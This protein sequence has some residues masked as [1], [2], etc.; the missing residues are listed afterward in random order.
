ML[1]VSVIVLA[2]G[3]AATTTAFSK[4]NLDVQTKMTD[5]IFL[6]PVAPHDRTVFVQV[7]NTS[8]Q[9]DF[10]I[11]PAVEASIAERGYRIVRR[12]DR[13]AL[14]ASGERAAGRRVSPTAAEQTFA[15]GFGSTLIGGAAGAARCR[16]ASD[17]T[18]ALIVGGALGAAT[19]SVAD[20]L[21]EDVTYSIIS[22][23]Q[24]SERAGE[25]VVV[26]ERLEQNLRQGDRHPDHLGSTQTSDWKR[27][28]T[29]IMS[30]ANQHQ[31][32]LRGRRARPGRRPHPLDRRHLLIALAGLVTKA[33]SAPPGA[34]RRS[35]P[36]PR[37]GP[38]IWSA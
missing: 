19:S 10:D 23:V 6:D 2:S 29:R 22:D 1:A 37:S 31:P 4:R 30:K 27:Y 26:T 5:T 28:R 16:I 34:A 18:R 13:G 17:D 24:I 9:A 38:P 33:A 15:G 11:A 20:A 35:C 21:I 36:P 25:G 7:R 14:P 32:R 3:C 8:D 12:P